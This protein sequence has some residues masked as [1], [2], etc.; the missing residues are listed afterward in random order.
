MQHSKTPDGDPCAAFEHPAQPDDERPRLLTPDQQRRAA[1]IR[2]AETSRRTA[3]RD[4]RPD[5]GGA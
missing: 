5:L 1:E 4:L 3:R 2:R